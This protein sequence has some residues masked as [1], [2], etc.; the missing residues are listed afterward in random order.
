MNRSTIALTAL[1]LCGT[2]FAVDVVLGPASGLRWTGSGT[3]R[4][5]TWAPAST[6]QADAY[7]G[8]C[9]SNG[10]PLAGYYMD[11]YGSGTWYNSQSVLPFTCP[12]TGARTLTSLGILAET[13]GSP[14][15]N[16]R[17][18][19]YEQGL[20]QYYSNSVNLVCQWS[21]AQLV[22]STQ[23]WWS[24]SSF[25]GTNIIY[26][27]YNYILAFSESSAL[28][29][30]GLTTLANASRF[31]APDYTSGFPD[32][33]AAVS[34]SSMRPSIR[35]FVTGGDG[36]GTHPPGPT[37]EIYYVDPSYTGAV[38]TGLSTQP[39]K[40]L[41][42]AISNKCNK[43]LTLPIQIRCRTS[44]GVPDTTCVSLALGSCVPSATNYIDIVA[45]TGHLAS[46][47]WDTNK[48]HLYPNWSQQA[49]TA[50][51]WG[52]DY[53]RFRNLQIGIATQTNAAEIVYWSVGSTGYMDGCVIKGL[54]NGSY[55]TRGIS[56]IHG[57]NVFNTI[58]Y[59]L[60]TNNTGA[61]VKNHGP[62]R[63]Q[64]C[65]ILSGGI[66]I[67]ITDGSVS[68]GKN[69]YVSSSG[70]AAYAVGG[71]GASFTMTTCASSDGTGSVGLTNIIANA[72]TFSNVTAG[73]EDWRL[74]TG[75]PLVNVGTDT[76]GDAAPFNFTNGIRGNVRSGSWDIGADEL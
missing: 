37:M 38:V 47:T 64:N 5:A 14:H 75:S 20:D 16:V 1:L 11:F 25:T 15:A 30:I 54:N 61:G 66:G 32:P 59:N 31:L 52:R 68:T 51:N 48:Y 67:D 53:T 72:S 17:V 76:S 45:E 3:T 21:A 24:S 58:I 2:A 73:A 39:Y 62:S 8:N 6:P 27:G 29:K 12:G 44:G 35:A 10:A 50:I 34:G 60:G 36:S 40:S 70:A 63:F 69:C 65:T 33:I 55:L 74:I 4:V 28:V 13:R 19:L 43:T 49:G 7:F 56:S 41:S 71:A 42:D 9:D 23:Q 26:G 18:A 46:T 22:N 57:V